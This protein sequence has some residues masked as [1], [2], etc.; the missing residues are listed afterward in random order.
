MN[1]EEQRAGKLLTLMS[2]QQ[3]R[4]SSE[5]KRPGWSAALITAIS[6]VCLLAAGGIGYLS[7]DAK[8]KAVVSTANQVEDL[9]KEMAVLDQRMQLTALGARVDEVLATNSQLNADVAQLTE[10]VEIL[11]AGQKKPSASRKR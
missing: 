1:Y 11:K 4:L 9:K 10:D 2:Q 6:A 3:D 5:R 8:I 7:I